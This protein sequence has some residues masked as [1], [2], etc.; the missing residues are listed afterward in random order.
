[1]SFGRFSLIETLKIAFIYTLHFSHK[2]NKEENTHFIRSV[3]RKVVNYFMHNFF[4]VTLQILSILS[5]NYSG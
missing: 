5:K 4:V 2:K 3:A 1:M